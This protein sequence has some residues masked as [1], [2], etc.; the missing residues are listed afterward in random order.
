MLDNTLQ[1]FLVD[2]GLGDAPSPS[3]SS[4]EG[5]G[6]GGKARRRGVARVK[7]EGVLVTC[8]DGPDDIDACHVVLCLAGPLQLNN[9]LSGPICSP[10][11]GLP[12]GGMLTL[13]LPFCGGTSTMCLPSHSTTRGMIS[14]LRSASSYAL[15]STAMHRVV[16]RWLFS[17]ACRLDAG[18]SLSQ[19]RAPPPQLC[20]SIPDQL[21]C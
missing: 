14:H 8:Q 20:K 6:D 18:N 5:G 1:D 13:C 4:S 9:F 19:G 15:G 3:S 12:C 17:P 7:T 10:L 2:S 16:R 21:W 11:F